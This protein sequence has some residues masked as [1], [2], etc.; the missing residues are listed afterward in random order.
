MAGNGLPLRQQPRPRR[1][2]QLPEYFK[3]TISQTKN[4]DLLKIYVQVRETSAIRRVV[5]AS[6]G[7]G[8]RVELSS[9]REKTGARNKVHLEPDA[10]RVLE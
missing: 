5:W 4:C 2:A 9:L 7:S 1:R 3:S 10:I 6:D 8:A